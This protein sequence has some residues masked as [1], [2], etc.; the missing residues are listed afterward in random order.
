M[1][2]IIDSLSHF[3]VLEN[4]RKLVDPHDVFNGLEYH[5]KHM[6]LTQSMK[7]M[8]HLSVV[9]TW[10]GSRQHQILSAKRSGKG[11]VKNET[12]QAAEEAVNHTM[13]NSSTMKVSH[14]AGGFNSM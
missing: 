5:A 7:E 1:E 12:R 8:H 6:F 4:L 3:V 14:A 2:G 10:S 11:V 13:A 9:T